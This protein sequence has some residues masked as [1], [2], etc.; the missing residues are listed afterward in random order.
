MPPV[1]PGVV[2]PGAASLAVEGWPMPSAC[3]RRRWHP[4]GGLVYVSVVH[5]NKFVL[6]GGFDG[7][8]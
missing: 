2:V 6:F 8:R 4:P 1:G 7:S 5:N 3:L